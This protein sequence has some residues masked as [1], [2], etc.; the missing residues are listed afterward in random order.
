MLSR[1]ILLVCCTLSV[2][3]A[4]SITCSDG[5]KCETQTD[6][7]LGYQNDIDNVHAKDSSSCCAACN[8]NSECVAWTLRASSSQSPNCYLHG[9]ANPTVKQKGHVS[10]LRSGPVPPPP[11]P[12]GPPPQATAAAAC[13]AL[14]LTMKIELMHGFGHIDGYSRNRCAQKLRL[15]HSLANRATFL[16]IVSETHKN[17]NKYLRLKN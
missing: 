14:N 2:I 17:L 1:L 4:D 15:T 7:I 11:P 16:S 10:G 3:R 13:A 9:S 8:K 6:V 12:P 5:T